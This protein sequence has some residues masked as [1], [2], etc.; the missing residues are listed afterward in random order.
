MEKSPGWVEKET[1]HTYVFSAGNDRLG[2]Q[3]SV[4]VHGSQVLRKRITGKVEQIRIQMSDWAIHL[5]GFMYEFPN[6]MRFAPIKE[7]DF[8][9]GVPPAMKNPPSQVPREPRHC[10]AI[11]ARTGFFYSPNLCFERLAQTLVRI[12]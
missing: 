11:E 5:Y 1:A 10:V 7:P 8:P 6:P 9:V 12:Q 4:T 3:S 2:R